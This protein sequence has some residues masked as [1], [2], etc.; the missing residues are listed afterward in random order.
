MSMRYD[1]FMKTCYR[2][3]QEKPLEAFHRQTKS[4]DGRQATCKECCRSRSQRWYADNREK[5]LEYAR[6]RREA[7]DARAGKFGLTVD[8]LE[9]ILEAY[10]DQ[11]GICG[12]VVESPK[13]LHLDHDHRTG[14]VRG[15]L[16]MHCNMGLGQFRDDPERLRKAINYLEL[17]A[18]RR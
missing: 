6:A 12:D 16:C 2:C 18:R 15:V 4:K 13:K 9:E 10:G 1:S 7:V 8:E 3:H 5:Y 17:A 14:R 11:C